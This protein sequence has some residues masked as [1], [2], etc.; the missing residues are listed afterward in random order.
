MKIPTTAVQKTMQCLLYNNAR[1]I[2]LKMSL[3]FDTADT[4]A[5]KRKSRLL[6]NSSNSRV[7]FNNHS[8]SPLIPTSQDR[9]PNS[10]NTI[11]L[12]ESFENLDTTGHS[13]DVA[14]F[15]CVAMITAPII[16]EFFETSFYSSPGGIPALVYHCALVYPSLFAS[17][18]GISVHLFCIFLLVYNRCRVG[19]FCYLAGIAILVGAVEVHCTFGMVSWCAPLFA[20][21]I[22]VTAFGNMM[23]VRVIH[24]EQACRTA[25][26]IA[27]Y[28]SLLLLLVLGVLGQYFALWSNHSAL[29]DSGLVAVS[30]VMCL[31]ASWQTLLPVRIAF[32]QLYKA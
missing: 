8:K 20:V 4:H 9:L 7:I 18:P 25:R 11:S 21:S 22:V 5:S 26:V 28:A 12:A 3:L 27:W 2:E 14:W 30:A 31:L 13:I 1:A 6:D 15:V 19:F 16:Y 32:V 17:L 23:L 10:C 24:G 29:M